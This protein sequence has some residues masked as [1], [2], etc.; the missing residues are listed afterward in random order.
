MIIPY[1]GKHPV[2]GKNV[3]IAPTAAVI[4]DVTIEDGA[5]VWFNAVVRGDKDRI[6][7]GARTNVQDHCI[8]HLDPG[9]PL[10]I[11]A[12]V[13]IGHNAVVH[14]C[15]IEDKVLIGIGAVVL[16]DAVVRSGSVV[17]AGAV[18]QEGQ[19][20]GPCQLAAGVPAKIKK[21]YGEDRLAVNVGEALVYVHLGRDYLQAPE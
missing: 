9:H 15:T 7:I 17:G 12:D 18:V 2:I 4:G 3:Y 6:T 10:T 21:D 5:S 20:I 11:G 1:K 13:T 8:L 16:N 14:G 19:Q